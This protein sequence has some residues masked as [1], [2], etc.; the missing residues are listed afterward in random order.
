[1]WSYRGQL[2]TAAFP[3]AAEEEHTRLLQELEELRNRPTEADTA[4][5]EAARQAAIAEMTEKVDKAKDRRLW[6]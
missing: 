2:W 6:P 5:V 4:A 1:M 3:Q